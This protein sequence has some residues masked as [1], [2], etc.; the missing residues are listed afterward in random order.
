[1]RLR[2][3]P[4]AAS[5]RITS[6]RLYLGNIQAV[7]SGDFSLDDDSGQPFG[8]DLDG[9][10]VRFAPFA[11]DRSFV[12]ELSSRMPRN[13]RSPGDRSA[14]FPATRN[15][16]TSMGMAGSIGSAGLPHPTAVHRTLDRSDY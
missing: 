4:S 9:D 5:S 8:T 12:H 11:E 14:T 10:G 3:S 1:M 13:T 2:A 6:T 15:S 7:L 16:S